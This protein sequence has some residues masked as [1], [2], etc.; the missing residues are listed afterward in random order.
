[1][2]V[3]FGSGNVKEREFPVG[4]SLLTIIETMRHALGYSQDVEAHIGGVPQQGSLTIGNGLSND[5]VVSIHD[6]PKGKQ[7]A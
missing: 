5:M 6:K 7:R 2:I 1:M 3:K 4:T